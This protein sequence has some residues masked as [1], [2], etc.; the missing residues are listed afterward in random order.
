ME[1]RK[2]GKRKFLLN[3]IHF[4]LK[5]ITHTTYEGLEHVPPSGGVLIATNHLSRLDI[6]V[7]F[8]IPAR[9]EITCVITTKYKKN[10]L[11]APLV[12]WGEGIWIDRDIADFTAIRTAFDVLKK[13]NA[14]GISPEGTRSTTNGLLPGK[15]GII[16][17]ALRSGV[18]IVP[19]G[20][21]GTVT[22][23]HELVRFR[24][25]KMK[26]TFGPAFT[27]PEIGRENRESEMQ[28]WTDE[29][30]CRIAVLLPEVHRGVY[31]DHPRVKE[32]EKG[33]LDQ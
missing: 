12:W 2:M 10:I 15:S 31:R 6:P 4:L 9:P 19:V 23:V 32:L 20:I 11:I 26:A 21:T 17:L 16:F 30:M 24:K 27:I 3:I 22:G 5:T 25:P 18:P 7:L 8:D 28:R 29:V 14:L 33:K 1:A 13:G